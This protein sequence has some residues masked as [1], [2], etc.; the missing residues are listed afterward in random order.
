M[1]L[2]ETCLAALSCGIP[3]RTPPWSRSAMG[4]PRPDDAGLQFRLGR[5]MPELEQQVAG[6]PGAVIPARPHVADGFVV[7]GECGLSGRDRFPGPG[8]AAERR[9][10]TQGPLGRTRHAAEADADIGDSAFGELQVEGA[11]AG[12]DVL[13]EALGNLVA[14]QLPGRIAAGEQQGFDKLAGSTVL[15]AIGNEIRFQRDLPPRLA[16]PQDQACSQ[17][18]Q[19]WRAVADGGA[20]GDI[21]DHGAAVPDLDRSEPPQDFAEIWIF[22]RDDREQ[23][24]IGDAGADL[25]FLLPDIEAL[26]FLHR[27]DIDDRVKAPMLFADPEADIGAAG[28]DAGVGMT[29]Q[30]LGQVVDVAWREIASVAGP[31]WKGAINCLQGDDDLPLIAAEAVG[32]P[33]ASH[34]PGRGDDGPIT[35][36]AAEVAGQ[37]IVDPRPVDR[38]AV[39]EHDEE[40]HDESRS[41]ESAL[42]A[43]TIH[44]GLLH[45][46]KLAVGAR[47]ILDSQ[48][49][50]AVK[51]RQELDAGVDGAID[52]SPALDLAKR[53]GASPAVPFGAPFLAARAAFPA[54]HIVENR[55]GRIV[56]RDLAPLLAQKETDGF[57]QGRLA[58]ARDRI[59][60]RGNQQGY[61]IVL[62]RI[63]YAEADHHLIEKPGARQLHAQACEVVASVENE[64]VGADSECRTFEKGLLAAAVGIGCS[65]GDALASV[66]DA[67][68]LDAHSGAR[69]AM[70]G[71][72]DMGRQTAH[73]NLFWSLGR[74]VSILYRHYIVVFPGWPGEFHASKVIS[75]PAQRPRPGYLPGPLWAGLR[76][77]ALDRRNRLRCRAPGCPRRPRGLAC[78][79][80]GRC[81]GCLARTPDGAA[82]RPSRSCRPSGGPPRAYGPF[83][84]GAGRCGAG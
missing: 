34:A 32:G 20:V 49:L 2:P 46:V 12:R 71:I 41:A 30:Q 47:Q 14:T 28:E 74:R 80:A 15:L 66:G 13:V 79:H 9:L 33:V 64:F 69:P 37:R 62:R 58:P 16:V 22:V 36:A 35:R 51:R 61:V 60:V 7:P 26:Q 11:K 70:G 19:G 48:K 24:G 65:G 38:R 21:A 4:R 67:E 50:F 73:R 52:K 63:R 53:H 42:R 82:A 18:D 76:A 29:K 57:G 3:W 17:G 40:G 5:L 27:A 1:A 78:R 54:A 25:D 45:R 10:A 84:L 31:P 68:Q 81:G 8:P 83:C 59:S 6:D 75:T 55:D 77:L 23:A 44:H 43:V 39:M 72:Q 56:D